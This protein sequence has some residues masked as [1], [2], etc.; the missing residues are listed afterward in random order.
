MANNVPVALYISCNVF[1]DPPVATLDEAVCQASAVVFNQYTN[2][3]LL[4]TDKY[5][6]EVVGLRAT[7]KG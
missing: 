6:S 5:K 7:V 2:P 4:A 3:R 1:T